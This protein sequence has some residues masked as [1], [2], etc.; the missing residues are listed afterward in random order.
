MATNKKVWL[1][2]GFIAAVLGGAAIASVG[3]YFWQQRQTDELR[4]DFDSQRNQLEERI[5]TL[6]EEA[7]E[8]KTTKS[9][10]SDEP[11]VADTRTLVGPSGTVAFGYEAQDACG[12]KFVED[13][14]TTTEPLKATELGFSFDVPYNP[15]WG[16]SECRVTPYD[17]FDVEDKGSNGISFGPLS[18]GEG[19]VGRSY[20]LLAI[21]SR[22]ATQAISAIKQ[23]QA[24][25]LSE[26][27]TRSSV[28]DLTI[29]SYGISGGLCPIPLIEIIGEDHNYLL[30]L[31]CTD[32]D[33]SDEF[34]FMKDILEGFSLL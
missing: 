10:E 20:S 7:K 8:P 24:E 31:G 12:N 13:E 6:E 17:F 15:D 22:T 27:P 19:G 23:E 28:G 33:M 25:F 16:T 1:T 2:V 11:V 29:V 34:V 9:E 3:V 26:G 4:K 30:N 18:A 21:D 14:P 5:K 32:E